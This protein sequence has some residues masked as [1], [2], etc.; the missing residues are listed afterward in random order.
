MR[1]KR[2]LRINKD[3]K[4]AESTKIS[5]RRLRL[6]APRDPFGIIDTAETGSAAPAWLSLPHVSPFHSLARAHATCLP[7]NHKAVLSRLI[8]TAN[9]IVYS[10]IP[11]V[12]LRHCVTPSLSSSPFL[13]L[14]SVKYRDAKIETARDV[15]SD[16]TKARNISA[17]LGKNI[18]PPTGEV[19][20]TGRVEH[21]RSRRLSQLS[22]H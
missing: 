17:R 9:A 3:L 21:P 13:F 2:S 16:T 22:F 12:C 6:D 18:F 7:I 1:K 5:P 14:F 20:K 10:Y 19:N 4:R 11:L 8:A 15:K